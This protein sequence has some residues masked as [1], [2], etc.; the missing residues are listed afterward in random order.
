MSACG[1][2]DQGGSSTAE[3]AASEAEYSEIRSEGHGSGDDHEGHDLA[4]GK[5]TPKDPKGRFYL[6][7]GDRG[8]DVVTLQKRLNELGADVGSA[9]GLFGDRTLV[10]VMAFQRA[11]DLQADGVVGTSTWA[12]LDA[13]AT[14]EIDWSVPD[15]PREHSTGAVAESAGAA[16]APPT[17]GPAAKGDAHRVGPQGAPANDPAAGKWAKAVVT[18][19]NQQATFY[20]AAGN[21]VFQ[22]P[23]SS[24]KNGLTPTGTFHV[25]SKSPR[26]FAGNGVY[27]DWMTRFNGGV[28]FHS[29]PK[30]SNGTDLPTPL[31]QA[32]VSHGCIRMADANAE[33]V[34]KNLPIGAVVEVH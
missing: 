19:S 2:D 3:D 30:R 4:V 32:P 20:D 17:T 18:L 23:I 11:E 13:P 27:M 8:P 33:L 14:I 31:G 10:A 28:G 1:E 9:D 24:G 34:F 26:A 29:I 22:A 6:H 25:Q 16:V 12:A 15:V 7:Q 5:N 21:I